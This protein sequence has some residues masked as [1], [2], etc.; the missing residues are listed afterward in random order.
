MVS[1]G[2]EFN[3]V[4]CDQNLFKRKKKEHKRIGNIGVHAYPKNVFS[5]LLFEICKCTRS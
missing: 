4:S 2:Y 3:L 5:Q 1:H